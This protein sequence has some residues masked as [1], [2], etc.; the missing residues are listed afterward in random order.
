MCSVDH[1]SR[2]LRDDRKL[3]GHRLSLQR[4]GGETDLS[5]D[6]LDDGMFDCFP[7]LCLHCGCK[8]E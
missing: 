2:L 3:C 6:S 5:R 7:A 4:M 8:T 1:V